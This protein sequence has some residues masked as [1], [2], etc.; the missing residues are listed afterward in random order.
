M[1]AAFLSGAAF[2]GVV[3]AGLAL[4]N[5]PVSGARLRAAIAS[6]RAAAA[7]GAEPTEP[8]GGVAD[9]GAAI[10]GSLLERVELARTEATAAREE[11]RAEL[12]EEWDRLRAQSE[13][14]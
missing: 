11:T 4:L 5:A 7:S 10:L 12:L 13:R 9:A 8:G 3:G 2:G 1:R 14:L 6:R